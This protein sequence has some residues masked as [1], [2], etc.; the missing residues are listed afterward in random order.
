[1]RDGLVEHTKETGTPE[2]PDHCMMDM[3]IDRLSKEKVAG[4]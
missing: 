3:L 4:G 2:E 1:M